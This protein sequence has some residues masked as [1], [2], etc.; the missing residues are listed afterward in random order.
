MKITNTI[1]NQITIWQKQVVWQDFSPILVGATT[2]ILLITLGEAITFLRPLR[3]VL[4]L[5]YVLF[6][7]GYCLTTALFPRMND[8]ENVER[9][10]L[11]LGFSVASVSILA[12]VL[13]WLHVGLHPWSIVLGEFAMTG[14]FMAVTSRKRSQLPVDEI[15]IPRIS[16]PLPRAV[17]SVSNRRLYYFLMPALVISVLAVWVFLTPISGQS[18]SEFY[19]LGPDGLIADYP[20]QMELNN[21]VRVN[22][23]IINR[24]KGEVNYHF[25]VWVTDSLNPERRERV[26]QSNIFS[27]RPGEKY[28]HP[29]SWHMPWAGDD[30]KVE[31]LL[32]YNNDSKPSRQ[33]KMWINVKE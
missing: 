22:V 21:E 11:S 24:E 17:L 8:L 12:L 3:V 15:Y 23:G 5:A 9:L 25:E 2:L 13:D 6:V 18:V 28:E 27:L 1:Q 4:G 30:Q 26:L 10:G 20:Y 32:F 29:V 14:F 7:P 31:L 19:I 16:W 33:L